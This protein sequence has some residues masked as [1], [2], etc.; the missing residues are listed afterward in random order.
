MMTKALVPQ[1]SV[2]RRGTNTSVSKD[3]SVLTGNIQKMRKILVH[4]EDEVAIWV[5]GRG[6]S[7]G[8]VMETDDVSV[9]EMLMRDD[10][11][12][13]TFGHI[14][15]VCSPNSKLT[16]VAI[17]IDKV[18]LDEPMNVNINAFDV[19]GGAKLGVAA[20]EKG[21]TMSLQTNVG[22]CVYGAKL[23]RRGGDMSV[24][25]RGGFTRR[26]HVL[27]IMGKGV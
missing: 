27:F 10:A 25:S 19:D 9:P 2:S 16:G 17:L 4:D 5:G 20:R 21:G 15:R 26:L 6:L 12:G 7:D 13:T 8:M 1:R 3:G 11:W 23:G 18:E 14:K 24:E 22:T